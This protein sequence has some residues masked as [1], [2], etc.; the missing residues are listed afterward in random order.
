MASLT[1]S[2]ASRVGTD[3]D[4]GNEVWEK[5]EKDLAAYGKK[6]DG[7]KTQFDDL[8][9]SIDGFSKQLEEA[10]SREK[11]IS[12]KLNEFLKELDKAAD[13][14]FSPANDITAGAEADAGATSSEMRTDSVGDPLAMSQL[15]SEKDS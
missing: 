14:S 2:M 6:I 8:A 12:D 5:L 10:Q 15:N 9:S 13:D 3:V 4:S 7:A 11:E 1:S